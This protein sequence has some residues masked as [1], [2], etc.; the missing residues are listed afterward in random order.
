[1]ASKDGGPM[2]VKEAAATLRVSP[3]VVYRLLN[4]GELPGHKIGG[5]WR[6]NR[7]RI[8]AMTEPEVGDAFLASPRVGDE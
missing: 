5:S 8:E 7:R 3:R 6:L 1:M 4:A 2:T